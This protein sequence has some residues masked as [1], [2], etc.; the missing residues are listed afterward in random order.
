MLFYKVTI[1]VI[2]HKIHERPLSA[3]T[4]ESGALKRIQELSII[5]DKEYG[6]N[7]IDHFECVELELDQ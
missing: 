3:H 2:W 1:F 4:T 7:T 6:Y 5:E